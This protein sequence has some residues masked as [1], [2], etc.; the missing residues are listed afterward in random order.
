[1]RNL[2]ASYL[3]A[4]VLVAGVLSLSVASVSYA[5]TGK[6]VAAAQTQTVNINTASAQQLADALNGVGLKKAEAIVAYR[7][8][9]GKF[10]SIDQLTEVKGIGK[11]TVE[12]NK[13]LIT[14]K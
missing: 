9:V 6:Q 1:M 13:A 3:F 10:I 12:K 7:K 5:D 2:R 4:L 8:S 11:A 14:L